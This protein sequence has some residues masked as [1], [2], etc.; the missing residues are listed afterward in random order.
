MKRAT[1]ESLAP[2]LVDPADHGAR[3]DSRERL[4]AVLEGIKALPPRQGRAVVLRELCGLSYEAIAD[5]LQTTVPAVK[6]LLVRARGALDPARR[7]PLAAEF[8]A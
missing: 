3:W 4:A 7:S 6:S 8:A 5:E 1:V 2:E